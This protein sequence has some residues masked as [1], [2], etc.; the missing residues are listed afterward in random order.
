[1][2][3][4]HLAVNGLE[5][6]LTYRKYF[7]QRLLVVDGRFATDLDYLFV[8]Q[9]IVEAKQVHDWRQKPCRQFTASQ[10]IDQTVLS[11]Y[12]RKHKAYPSNWYRAKLMLYYPLYDEQAGLLGRFSTYEEHYRRVHCWA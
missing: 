7:N 6:K 12:V 4:V 3:M 1:M 5:I 11:Q 10:A 9:H 8:A 2:G